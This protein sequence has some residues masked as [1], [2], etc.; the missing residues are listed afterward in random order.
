MENHLY[1]H[2][3]IAA[4]VIIVVMGVLTTISCMG[5]SSVSS[6]QL[7]QKTAKASEEIVVEISGAV[8]MP[9][10]YTLKAGTTVRDAVQ[11]AKPLPEASLSRLKLD[12]PVRK[13]QKI[14][15]PKKGRRMKEEG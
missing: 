5:N 8:E 4:I 3:W 15:V 7:I 12:K 2:E 1:I 11:M 10:R 14:K 9:G 13:G 6:S